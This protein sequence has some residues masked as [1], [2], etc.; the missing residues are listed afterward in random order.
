MGTNETKNRLN[1]DM[2]VQCDKNGL[3]LMDPFIKQWPKLKKAVYYRL[4][5]KP[6]KE[7]I[8]VR[9][10]DKNQRWIRL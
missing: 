8:V 3:I 4:F 9:F 10:Y 6:K 1:F 5:P 2:S 7:S